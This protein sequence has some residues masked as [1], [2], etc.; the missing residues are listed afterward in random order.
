M[1][2]SEKEKM[3]AGELYDA[4]DIEVLGLRLHAHDLCHALSQVRPSDLDAKQEII[5]QL[6]P[7][8]EEEIFITPPFFCDYGWNITIGKK[9]YCNAG[10][11]ILDGAPVHI[12]NSV[13]LAPNVHIYTATHAIDPTE[14]A[15][16]IQWAKPVH[17]GNKVWIGGNATICPGVRIG[18]GTVIGAGSVV[19]KDI[20]GNVIAGGNPCRIIRKITP[21]D[22]I[23]TAYNA[24]YI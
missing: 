22:K 7:N 10:C 2:L 17:I 13:L 14:R 20:P 18:D 8:A 1:A 9:F 12:G 21:A 15:S 4:L 3:T 19:T 6:L 16:L 11:V 23:S 5:R 24:P